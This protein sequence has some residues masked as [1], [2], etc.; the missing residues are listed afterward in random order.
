M[1]KRY[2]ILS[3]LLVAILL[4]GAL[5]NTLLDDQW[6]IWDDGLSWMYV[7]SGTK[8]LLEN[9]KVDGTY[10]VE[11]DLVD[12][13]SNLGKTI[14]QQGH[15]QRILI[16]KIEKVSEKNEYLV[17]L[18]S[19]CKHNVFGGELVTFY[20][21]YPK[22]E[23]KHQPSIETA[24]A[25]VQYMDN[26]YNCITVDSWKLVRHEGDLITYQII[27]PEDVNVELN[28]KAVLTVS[29]LTENKWSRNWDYR[30]TK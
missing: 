2:I 11:L 22:I 12:L 13:E 30:E 4:F 18:Y 29:N 10:S 8:Y 1:K 9:E 5:F 17:T 28:D 20:A 19:W 24:N 6:E 21:H 23:G 27:L 25:V 14:F 7:V 16:D 26:M 3:G 15:K